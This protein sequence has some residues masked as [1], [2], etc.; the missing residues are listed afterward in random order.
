MGISILRWVR[1]AMLEPIR[2]VLSFGRCRGRAA[3]MAT[4]PSSG[5]GAALTVR[6]A[7]PHP[8]PQEIHGAFSRIRYNGSIWE[9]CRNTEMPIDADTLVIGKQLAFGFA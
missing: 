7:D 9:L 2:C 3:T 6:S 4:G 8:N 5:V 1:E